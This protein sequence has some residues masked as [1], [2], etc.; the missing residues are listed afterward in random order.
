MGACVGALSCDTHGYLLQSIH[1]SEDAE[2]RLEILTGGM[3]CTI[4]EARQ[5]AKQAPDWITSFVTPR[6]LIARSYFLRICIDAAKETAEW[7]APNRLTNKHWCIDVI[8]ALLELGFRPRQSWIPFENVFYGTQALTVSRFLSTPLSFAR[9]CGAKVLYWCMLEDLRIPIDANFFDDQ[10]WRIQKFSDLYQANQ[11]VARFEAIQDT[12][13]TLKILLER[14]HTDV[15]GSFLIPQKKLTFLAFAATDCVFE[16][17]AEADG[18]GASN[19]NWLYAVEL[20][21]QAPSE[22][23]EAKACA[24]CKRLSTYLNAARDYRQKLCT[25]NTANLYVAPPIFQSIIVP[26]M[27][28]F[29]VPLFEIGIHS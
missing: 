27:F 28:R 15:G 29:P 11:S 22:Q 3:T 14:V 6:H 4:D 26:L 9:S 23:N 13:W 21:Q 12:A 8:D 10:L 24:R 16:V 1:R 5:F 25:W 7:P 19:Y 17:I 18:A 2:R 20:A